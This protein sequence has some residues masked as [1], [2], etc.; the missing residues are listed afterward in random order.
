MHRRVKK[1]A[2]APSDLDRTVV[3][4]FGRARPGQADRFGPAWLAPAASAHS[5]FFSV[6]WFFP[7]CKSLLDSKMGRNI[8]VG[9]KLVIQISM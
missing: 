1:K 9:L 8:S 4:R 3:Y 5:V 6:I 2:C 7:F